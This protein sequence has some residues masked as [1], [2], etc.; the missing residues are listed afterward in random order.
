MLLPLAVYRARA[1]GQRRWWI[2]AFLILMGLLA[3]RS[4]TAVLMMFA[5]ILVYILLRP[6]E[7]KRLW[8]AIIPALIAIHFV[9]PG[10][11]G[12]IKASFFPQGGLVAQQQNAAV[13]SGRIAT[14]G[15]ALDAEWKPNPIAG[16]GFGTRITGAA[17]TGQPSPNGPILDDQW[18]GT[19]LEVGIVGTLAWIWLFPRVVRRLWRAK[20]DSSDDGW[21]FVALAASITAFAVGMFTYD[22]F[23]FVQV[24]FVLFILLGL[25]GARADAARPSRRTAC[26]SRSRPRLRARSPG[27][28]PRASRS[29]SG[30]SARV[31]LLAPESARTVASGH[32]GSRRSADPA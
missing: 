31:T 17:E 12:T 26:R 22:A 5:V 28:R 9:L 21:L 24:T 27:R 16:E 6:K 18:L 25:G 14:L 32:R 3:T 4:R 30:S 13:G 29:R 19:L 20:E 7:M 8:P 15:P 1:F 11:I 2:P 23:S 10:T